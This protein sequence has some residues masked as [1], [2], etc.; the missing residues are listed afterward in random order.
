MFTQY[1]VIVLLCATKWL[2]GL[3][4]VLIVEPGLWTAVG[5]SFGGGMLGVLFYSYLGHIA[6]RIWRLWH[7]A[8]KKGIRVTR[9]K[10][11]IVTLRRRHGLAGIAALTPVLLTVPIGTFSA[12]LI[13]PRRARVF[14]YMAMSFGFWSVTLCILDHTFDHRIV[15]SVKSLFQPHRP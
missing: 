5:L 7:P 2:M 11:L 13:E 12:L 6:Y 10:R 1:L 3:V 14:L 15:E 4:A 9:M 8:P